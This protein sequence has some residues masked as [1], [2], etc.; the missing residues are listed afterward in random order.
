MNW[1]LFLAYVLVMTFSPGV[2]N[3]T[4][5]IYGTKY[6]KDIISNYLLGIFSGFF[7][8]MLGTGVFSLVLTESF[9]KMQTY[10]TYICAV[11]LFFMSIHLLFSD[12]QTSSNHQSS[13]TRMLLVGTVLQFFNPKVIL[14][15]MVAMS[16]ILP[17]YTSFMEMLMFSLFLA[18]VSYISCKVWS[19]FGVL[20]KDFLVKNGTIYKL[21][22]SVLFATSAYLM[23]A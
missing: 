20:I 7:I 14:H 19:L 12:V 6:D 23:I 9:P 8:V 22:V 1:L 5:M 4:S 16:Y 2:N 10:I 13:S 18:V 17:H 3:I 15:G 21:V 11:Y